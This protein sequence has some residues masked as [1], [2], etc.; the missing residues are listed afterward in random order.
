MPNLIPRMAPEPPAEYVAF[1]SH[2]LATLPDEAARLV[3]DERHADEIYPEALADVAARWSWF[4]LLRDVAGPDSRSRYLR[5]SLAQRAKRWRDEQP[6]PVEVQ[7]LAPV[8]SAPRA[9]APV[10]MSVA[11]RRAP[12]VGSTARRE[13]R[14][15]AEAAIAWL[16]AYE[17]YRRRRLTALIVVAV[18]VFGTLAQIAGSPST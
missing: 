10:W 1:V 7:V 17:R 11:L 14:P 4:D 3:G 2:H 9:P 8:P 5:R 15:L 18:L 12:L 6:Y 16:T 13:A